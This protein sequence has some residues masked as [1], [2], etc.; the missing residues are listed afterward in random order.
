MGCKGSKADVA[1]RAE[2]RAEPDDRKAT[3]ETIPMEEVEPVVQVKP[4][5]EK[6]E[7]KKV[8]EL[9]VESE[10][11][12]EEEEPHPTEP[13]AQMEAQMETQVPEVKRLR[14]AS[15]GDEE[16]VTTALPRDDESP[17]N[18]DD[19]VEGAREVPL[20]AF[21]NWKLTIG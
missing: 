19:K 10:C 15:E 7:E 2:T 17:H 12:L 4:E 21:C 13:V 3:T 20:C 16:T 8:E 11:F 1:P 9:K 18:V 5:V 6:V 14:G